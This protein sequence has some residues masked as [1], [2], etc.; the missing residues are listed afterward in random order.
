MGNWDESQV[1]NYTGGEEP[2][3][4]LATGDD[5]LT[6]LAPSTCSHMMKFNS[7]D[8]KSGSAAFTA[9]SKGVST[10]GMENVIVSFDWFVN[11]LF[12]VEGQVDLDGK[13][14]VTYS[15]KDSA[16]YNLQDNMNYRF[17]SGAWTT[18][19]SSVTFKAGIFKVH[20]PATAS[21]FES[22]DETIGIVYKPE[23]IF[24]SMTYD[25][26]KGEVYGL[27]DNTEYRI[28]GGSWGTATSNVQ[29]IPGYV[30]IRK[31]ASQFILESDPA[32]HSIIADLANAPGF[33][34]DHLT[35]K[36]NEIADTTYEY[37]LNNFETSSVKANNEEIGL[38]PG[39]TLSVRKRATS[40][41]LPSKYQGIVV[42]QRPAGPVFTLDYLSETTN[43][44]LG[45]KL[46]FILIRLPGYS[47]SI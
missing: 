9:M 32:L 17:N 2:E 22:W 24:S 44:L 20:E 6:D 23:S 4:T 41:A 43:E 40:S 42:P 47:I 46:Q 16:V 39:T 5:Y 28:S 26:A 36:T 12:Y 31:P 15:V 37:S 34:I 3:I 30:E 33:T 1:A 11:D 27:E 13:S 21:A 29:F 19:V 45:Y 38:T 8:C 7:F 35:E 10:V 14:G 25:I 18:N